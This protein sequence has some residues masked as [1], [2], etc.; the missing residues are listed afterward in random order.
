MLRRL[1]ADLWRPYLRPSPSAQLFSIGGLFSP[2][3]IDALTAGVRR[4]P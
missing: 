4:T 2:R 1:L 3:D